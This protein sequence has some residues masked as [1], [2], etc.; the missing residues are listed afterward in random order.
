MP[1]ITATNL[2][3]VNLSETSRRVF[4]QLNNG[5]IRNIVFSEGLEILAHPR[6]CTPLAAVAWGS[7]E[8]EEVSIPPHFRCAA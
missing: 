5:E 3:A 6:I 1:P 8:E 2:S 7:S 4:Y